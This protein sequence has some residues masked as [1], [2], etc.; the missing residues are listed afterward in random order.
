MN[1]RDVRGAPTALL[2]SL[3]L[4]VTLFFSHGAHAQ[5]IDVTNVGGAQTSTNVLAGTNPGAPIFG[6]N[7]ELISA[8]NGYPILGAPTQPVQTFG[9]GIAAPTIVLPPGSVTALGPFPTIPTVFPGDGAGVFSGG[10]ISEQHGARGLVTV[11]ENRVIGDFTTLL[12]ALTFGGYLAFGSSLRA[13]D[14]GAFVAGSVRGTVT[15]GGDVFGPFALVFGTD[16]SGPL[17]DFISAATFS[18]LSGANLLTPA[19]IGLHS[20]GKAGIPIGSTVRIDT[21]VTLMAGPGS[22][23]FSRLFPIRTPTLAAGFGHR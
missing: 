6:P 8:G 18:E 3:S 17:P 13:D 14:P 4:S 15:I 11:A 19:G 5:L 22:S 10:G 1:R 2:G 7:N 23:V 21:T 12:D 16:G 20:L 9:G